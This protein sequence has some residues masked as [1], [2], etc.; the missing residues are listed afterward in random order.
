MRKV[1]LVDS[2][3]GRIIDVDSGEA[4]D[5]AVTIEVERKRPH[6]DSTGIALKLVGAVFVFAVLCTF[7]W[8]GLILILLV[9]ML[10]KL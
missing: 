8:P 1:I 7:G 2:T 9:P 6:V 4:T 3:R 5:V 10:S